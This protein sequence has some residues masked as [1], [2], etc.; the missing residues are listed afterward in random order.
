MIIIFINVSVDLGLCLFLRFQFVCWKRKYIICLYKLRAIFC[1]SNTS[2]FLRN[3]KKILENFRHSECAFLWVDAGKDKSFN[4]FRFV[5][6][7]FDCKIFRDIFLGEENNE[8]RI[9]F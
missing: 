4:D 9:T 8:T 1:Y 7:F 3:N 6:E 5:E 2:Q